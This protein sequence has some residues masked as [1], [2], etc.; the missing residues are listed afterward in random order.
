MSEDILLIGNDINNGARGNSWSDLLSKMNQ[1]FGTSVDFSDPKKPFPLAYE[2]FYFEAAVQNGHKEKDVLQ[3]IA[4]QTGAIEPNPIH[5]LLVSLPCENLF[6]TNYD[7]SLDRAISEQKTY[8]NVG[9][10]PEKTYNLFRKHQV[11]NKS[12]WHIHGV[13]NNPNSIVLGYNHY[14]GYLQYMRNYVVTGTK[15][16]YKSLPAT[17]LI[18]QLKSATVQHN[19][20][21]DF[22]FTHNI[23]ILGLSL[24]F[25]ESDLWWLLTYRRKIQIDKDKLI[26]IFNQIHY[27][28]PQKYV[29]SSKAKIDLLK[30][31]GV[32]VNIID[33]KP[34]TL[35]YY[36]KVSDLIA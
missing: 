15:D 17:Q 24:D 4:E 20:W 14:S 8:K 34:S 11:N 31:S 25:I 7:L 36:K 16:A 5:D 35:D 19:S 27:Y 29:A 18:K 2:E 3:F 28:I 12:I 13:A 9:V 30:S 23:H 21:I 10:V 1:E 22:F 33:A 6:T 32:M 26:D